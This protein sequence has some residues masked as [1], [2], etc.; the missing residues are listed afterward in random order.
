MATQLRVRGREKVAYLG[1]LHAAAF[2]G[3]P[4]PLM[5][6][7]GDGVAVVALCGRR[8]WVVMAGRRL[9]RFVNLV[10]DWLGRRRRRRRLGARVVM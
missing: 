3:F 9:G 7:I 5:P 1:L 8:R 10:C 2:A 4:Y 6:Y